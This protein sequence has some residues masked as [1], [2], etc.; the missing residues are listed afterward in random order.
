MSLQRNLLPA[1]YPALRALHTIGRPLRLVPAN[2]LRVLLYHDVAR[3]DFGRLAR[4]LSWLARRWTFVT[5]ENF[6]AMV[7]GE[8]P[9]HGD[10]LLLTFDDGFASNRGV[11]E[12][13]LDPMGVKAIFFVVSDF[14]ASDTHNAARDF[15]GRQIIP[16][17]SVA[18][19]PAH[20]ENMRWNDLSALLE[21][22]HTIGSHTR[23]HVRLSGADSA[24]VLEDEIA[25]SADALERRLGVKIDHFAYPFGDLGSFNQQALEVARRRYRFVYSGLRGDNGQ[26][27]LPWSL[28]R[29]SITPGDSLALLG[30][31]LEGGADW[32]YAKG[33]VIYQDWGLSHDEALRC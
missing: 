11:A 13:V 4:Q 23:S 31:F 28:W 27:L 1:A 15:I 30:A 16:G 6:A 21:Q 10:N 3:E 5:P 26:T 17:L 14:V 32:R 12:A 24:S 29:D 25:E 20:W 9:I 19:M 33:R 18:E 7:L 2:R 22:G 8:A